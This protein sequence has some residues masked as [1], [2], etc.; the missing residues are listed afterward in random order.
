[1]SVR[2]RIKGAFS[3]YLARLQKENQEMFGSGR[4]DCCSLNRKQ[5]RHNPPQGKVK[6]C[7][8]SK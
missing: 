6:R 3:R 5:M 2:G 1:M 4:P 7:S 8:G